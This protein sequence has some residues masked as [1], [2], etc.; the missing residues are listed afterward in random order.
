M[1]FTCVKLKGYVGTWLHWWRWAPC[2]VTWHVIPW[3]QLRQRWWLSCTFPHNNIHT[4][5]LLTP[6]LTPWCSRLPAMFWTSWVPK[7]VT[8][9]SP[10]HGLSFVAQPRWQVAGAVW[11]WRVAR[12]VPQKQPWFLRAWRPAL[13]GSRRKSALLQLAI[14]TSVLLSAAWLLRRWWYGL[15]WCTAGRWRSLS[16]VRWA[17]SGPCA[18]WCSTNTRAIRKN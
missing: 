14:S 13:S 7:S 1:R 17:S 2:W 6:Q 3:R 11:P 4:S 10:S 15:S 9:S 8:P 18:G 5:S 16:P 12:S